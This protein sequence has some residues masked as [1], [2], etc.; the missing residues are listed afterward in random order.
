[1]AKPKN[2]FMYGRIEF[3]ENSVLYMPDAICDWA[4]ASPHLFDGLRGCGKSS[5]LKALSWE[6]AWGKSSITVTGSDRVKALFREPSF[7]GVYH[8]VDD[9]D[10]GYW[11]RWHNATKGAMAQE[12]FGTYL[13]LLYL[14]LFLHALQEI[15]KIRPDNLSEAEAESEVV[16]AL[17]QECFPRSSLKPKLYD[18]SF[19][20]LRT[21]IANVHMAIR[22]LVF[23]CTESAELIRSICII[24]PGAL[25]KVL[26]KSIREH[27]SCMAKKSLLVLLDDYHLMAEW[28]AEVVNTAVSRASSPVAYKLASVKGLLRSRSTISPGRTIIEHEIRTIRV[29]VAA[30][31]DKRYMDLAQGICQTRI[32][33]HYGAVPARKF[34]LKRLLGRFDLEGS[35]RAK[36]ELSENPCAR[37][38]LEEA[39]A[40]EGKERQ[41]SVLSSWLF[42]KDV[43]KLPS[44]SGDEGQAKKEWRRM[45]S[46][47]VRK[48]LPVAAIALCKEMRLR[49][50]YWGLAVV[51]HLSNGSIRELLRVMSEMWNEADMEIERFVRIDPLDNSIQTRAI[52]KASKESYEALDTKMLFEN[53]SLPV[54]CNRLGRLFSTCQ[55]FPY[56][57]VAPET[58]AVRIRKEDFGGD[59]EAVVDRAVM[60][61]A[62]LKDDKNDGYVDVGLH[63]ILA[64]KFKLSYRQPFFYPEPVSREHITWLFMG[65]EAKAKEATRA[66]LQRRLSRAPAEKAGCKQ[67]VGSHLQLELDI[68]VQKEDC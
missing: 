41:G 58:A 16:R 65:D 60:A 13:E 66:I 33:Q 28:Q 68:D 1:M 17:V 4:T 26:G 48:F 43:R 7:I 40:K 18:E 3:E 9:M 50:P 57:L 10:I 19:L 24:G 62:L 42:M 8:C 39:A 67:N 53:S 22:E 2:P 11:Q 37:S 29:P 21:I 51:L 52:M 6:V 59:L 38:L 61:G 14:D 63:P 55:S 12:V 30:V 36:L 20:E 35:I 45:T 47:Y 49:F 31:T 15:R 5:I 44:F 27:Y 32:E 46:G 34:N 64:P 23:R 54:I 25:M 56:M